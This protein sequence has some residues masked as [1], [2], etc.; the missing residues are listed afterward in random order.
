MNFGDCPYCNKFTG[1]FK[2]PDKTPCYAKVKCESC[3]K[4]IWYRFS[5]ID[6]MSWTIEDFEKEFD[7]D[8]ENNKIEPK[9]KEI[10]F[11]DRLAREN[12]EILNKISDII[13][14][15]FE[16]YIING[17]PESNLKPVGILNTLAKKEK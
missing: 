16:D 1:F 3:G 15:T 6:P 7:I 11:F 2:V 12:P 13:R 14:K 8:Y 17:D 5:R 10:S 9:V 4:E